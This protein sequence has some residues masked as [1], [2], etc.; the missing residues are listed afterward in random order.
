MEG[1]TLYVFDSDLGNATSVCVDSCAVNWP[2][3]LL[4]DGDAS[5]IAGVGTVVR[6]DGSTQFDLFGQTFVFLCR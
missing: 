4:T 2:P 6:G 1:K 5:D 3:L